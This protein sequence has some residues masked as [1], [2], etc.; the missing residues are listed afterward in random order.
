MFGRNYFIQRD[1]QSRYDR[2]YSTWAEEQDRGGRRMDLIPPTQAEKDAIYLVLLTDFNIWERRM[3][4]E[5]NT[6]EEQ[7]SE[8]WKSIPELNVRD[9]TEKNFGRPKL[10][11]FKL[12]YDTLQ[13]ISMRFRQ[14]AIQIKGNPFYVSDVRKVK[15]QYFFLIENARDQKFQVCVDDIDTFRGVPPGYVTLDGRHGFLSRVPARVNQQGMSPQNTSIVKISTQSGIVYNVKGIVQAIESKGK[16][17]SWHR[18]YRDLML[19]RA[20]PEMRLSDDVAVFTKKGQDQIYVGYHG[21]IFGKMNDDHRVS[22]LDEDDLIQPWITKHF[23]K[24]NLEA[25]K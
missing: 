22:A 11:P 15:K 25:V 17:L 6:I 12:E 9:L 7:Q 8:I 10:K 4:Q 21:R 2:L 1:W 24:V 16:I 23:E 14:T 20:I 3:L 13:E 19:N 5:Q 18:N